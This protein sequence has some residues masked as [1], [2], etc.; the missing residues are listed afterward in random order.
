MPR[1]GARRLLMVGTL[2]A[3]SASALPTA[4]QPSDRFD[5]D[6]DAET[7][8]LVWPAVEVLTA[9]EAGWACARERGETRSNILTVVDY[10]LPSTAR[11]LW[12]IDLER[13]EILLHEHVAH[14]V[15]SGVL[16]AERF[17]DGMQRTPL[18]VHVTAS[19]PYQGR[20]GHSLRLIGL[21]PHINGRSL[22]RAVVLH[23]APYVTREQVQLEG[24]VGASWGCPAVAPGVAPQLIDLVKGGSVVVLYG[25]DPAWLSKS[26]YLDC[27][28]RF[29]A[30]RGPKRARA[31]RPRSV[32]PPAAKPPKAG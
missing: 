2:V 23:G 18:G 19:K 4:A 3:L 6:D 27:S 25:D 30:R 11:R 22:E 31:T 16:F 26:R 14:G 8:A 13:G 5:D 10:S 15:A 24:A 32:S 28:P 29:R 1:R 9:A 12:V 20:R 17:G 21:E 7:P